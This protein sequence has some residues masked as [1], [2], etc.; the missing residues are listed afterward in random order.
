M[1]KPEIKWIAV[2]PGVM[3]LPTTKFRI[4]HVN[5]SSVPFRVEWDGKRTPDG[6]HFTL[7]EAQVAAENYIDTLMTMGYEV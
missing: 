7:A 4:R 6:E 2:A 1:D 3:E 5:G